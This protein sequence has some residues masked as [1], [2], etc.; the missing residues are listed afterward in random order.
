MGIE[1]WAGGAYLEP[2]A[3]HDALVVN[4][5]AAHSGTAVYVAPIQ[6]KTIFISAT[7][8]SSPGNLSVQPQMSF[9]NS[10][11]FDLGSAVTFSATGN[12]SVAL[13]T[14]AEYYRVE[15]T[16]AATTDADNYWTVTATISGKSQG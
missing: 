14:H 11:W 12:D 5:E 16:S 13:T 6:E 3:S 9:D 8:T 4:D 7:K 1:S 10:T 15:S 2:T